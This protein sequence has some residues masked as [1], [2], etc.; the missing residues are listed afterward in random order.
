MAQ[1][2]RSYNY[3]GR[4]ALMGGLNTSDN[5]FIVAATQMTKA[6]NVLISQT[7]AR[8]KRP[9]QESYHTGSY[10]S[11]ASFPLSGAPI[12]GILQYWRYLSTTNEPTEDVFLHIRD[13]LW[14][15][16]SREDAGRDLTGAL[17]L[18][19][20]GV[21]DY[22][23]FEGILYFTSSNTSDGYNKWNGADPTSTAAVAA[24]PPP[25]GVGKYLST[26]KGRMVMAGNNSF[27]FR[28]YLST[29]L[30]AEV[31]DGIG[32][33][34]TSLDVSYD[35]DPS[36]ITALFG[37]FQGRFYFAT[38]TS[39]YELTGSDETDFEVNRLSSGIGCISNG[40]VVQTPNDIIFCS[41]RG[42]HSLRKTITSDQ[43]E[44]NFL[45]RDI[46]KTYTEDLTATSLLRSQAVW[47]ETQNLYILS[48]GN[49]SST[50]NNLLLVYNITFD[51]WTIWEQ[52][53]ARSM[54][55]ALLSNKVRILLGKEDGRIAYLN[56]ELSADFGA[57]Y[58]AQLKTGKIIPGGDLTSQKSFKSLT[59][60]LSSTTVGSITTNWIVESFDSNF[61][62][63]R[64][65]NLGSGLGLMGSTFILGQSTLGFG[66]F[67][68]IKI[69]IDEVGYNFQFELIISGSM[70]FE[71]YGFILEVG[72]E[73]SI[74]S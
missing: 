37:E 59:I 12:R 29:P 72:E 56:P 52:V 41:D 44:V 24:N 49:S 21:P 34:G 23:V 39:I 70:N 53:D 73:D 17:T 7:L 69:S 6:K 9:G 55:R 27:P 42:V 66:R 54:A 4:E 60:L 61:T 46:Q 15:L 67:I 63:S 22:Q 26:Y 50:G 43:T 5:P 57:G 48:V 47:D 3:F 51:L 65:V 71:F 62:G 40:S 45:S 11:T 13:E 14:A 35:G 58:A 19:T 18:S 74:Y 8:K 64:S 2:T 20:D 38:R 25:D 16:P 31:W 30:N 32:N 28:L 1:R 68:P 10:G 36:G 33:L